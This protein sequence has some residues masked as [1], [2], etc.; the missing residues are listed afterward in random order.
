MPHIVI[1]PGTNR[2]GA[3]SLTLAN[4]IAADYTALGCSVDLL[5][6]ELGPEFLAPTAYKQPTPG[7]TTLVGRFLVADGVV[8]VIP[9]YNGSYPGVLKLF[10]DMLPYP[11]GFDRRPCAF[12]GIGAGQFQGLR[13]VEH[14][15]G[16]AGYRNAHMYPNRVFLG[17]GK[18]LFTDGRLSDAKLAER[19][20][21]QATGFVK[22]AG[23][24]K[25][26]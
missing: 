17:A 11:Q 24:V 14:F 22:F 15:Q 18:E 19:L 25:G 6:L 16:V 8:F 3:V 23:A 20:K 2:A 9:E 4:L 13:A 1:I 21:A 5:A 10:T 12:V 7:I 26:S